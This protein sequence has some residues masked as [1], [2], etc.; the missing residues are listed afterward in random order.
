MDAVKRIDWTSLLILL[1]IVAGTGF[2]MQIYR[3]RADDD[4]GRQVA[5]YARPGDIH[6]LSSVS[7]V[8]CDRARAWFDRHRVPYSE[9]FVERDELCADRFRAAMTQGTPTLFVKGRRLVGFSAQ[10]V[11]DALR[12]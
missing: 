11:L 8:Y 2:G 4:L 12:Q 6:M 10:R 1:A 7:C 5:A 9:C 3:D